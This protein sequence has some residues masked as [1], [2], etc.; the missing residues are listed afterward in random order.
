MIQSMS[1]AFAQLAKL[2]LQQPDMVDSVLERMLQADPDLRWTLVVGAY[3]DGTISLSKAAELLHL[4]SLEL[5]ERFIELGIP[6][7]LGP[8]N[9]DEALAEAEAI[10]VWL[11]DSDNA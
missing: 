8:Q 1:W 9:M 11:S 5:R 7:Q 3:Q 2:Q 4:H 6:I 10:E